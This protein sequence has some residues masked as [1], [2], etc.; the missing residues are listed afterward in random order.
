MV[1]KEKKIF[2]EVLCT[3]YDLIRLYL[4][5]LGKPLNKFFACRRAQDGGR[6][7]Q[8]GGNVLALAGS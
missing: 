6:W 7:G 8:D 5:S 1:K 4:I 2:H 3:L